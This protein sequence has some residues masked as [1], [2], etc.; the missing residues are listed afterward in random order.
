VVQSSELDIGLVTLKV[1]I[2]LTKK[3]EL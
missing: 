1:L 2:K 3:L